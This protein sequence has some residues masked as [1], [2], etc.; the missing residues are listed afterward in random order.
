MQKDTDK[1]KRIAG[2][3]LSALVVGGLILI[4]TVCM[5]LD[6]FG[7]GGQGPETAVVLI[8]AGLFLL[9][10]IAIAAACIQ[11]FREIQK[12]EEDEAKKY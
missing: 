12:G 8:S 5:L 2:A 6:C 1:K 10:V 3:A 4:I 11:R 7:S 9:M